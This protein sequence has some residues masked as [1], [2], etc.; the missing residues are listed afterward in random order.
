MIQCS[1]CTL[2]INGAW[3]FCASENIRVTM[4]AVSY[5]TGWLPPQNETS[6]DLCVDRLDFNITYFVLHTRTCPLTSTHVYSVSGKHLPSRRPDE[7][8]SSRATSTLANFWRA[9]YLAAAFLLRFFVSTS[10][11]SPSLL[12]ASR[13]RPRGST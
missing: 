8:C 9:T 3:R 10:F 11:S 2:H 7:N 1:H 6:A 12:L 4:T 5:S 13:L